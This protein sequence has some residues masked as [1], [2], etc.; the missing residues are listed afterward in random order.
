MKQV[1]SFP[2]GSLNYAAW[3]YQMMLNGSADLPATALHYSASR[4]RHFRYALGVVH[5]GRRFLYSPSLQSGSR[6]V[7]E[8]VNELHS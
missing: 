2:A 5:S 8:S 1:L 4:A 3:H 7:K 6:Q